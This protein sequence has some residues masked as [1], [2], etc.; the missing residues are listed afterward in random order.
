MTQQRSL[1]YEYKGKTFGSLDS[2]RSCSLCGSIRSALTAVRSLSLS[3]SF[4]IHVGRVLSDSR[5]IL[6]LVFCRSVMHNDGIL[7]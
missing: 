1:F 3:R 2:S 5:L 4:N 7:S 6:T